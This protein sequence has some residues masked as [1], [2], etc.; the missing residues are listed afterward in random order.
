VEQEQPRPIESNKTISTMAD[1]D[2]TEDEV[3]DL[4]EAFAMFDINGDGR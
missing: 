3:A 1:R 4:K 2:L